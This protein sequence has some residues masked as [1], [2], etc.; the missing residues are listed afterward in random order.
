[1]SHFNKISQKASDDFEDYHVNVYMNLADFTMK[2]VKGSHCDSQRLVDS[3]LIKLLSILRRLLIKLGNC[4][5]YGLL[6]E[7][8]L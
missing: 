6:Y 2:G 5:C 8:E 7:S 3:C 4:L 1:M